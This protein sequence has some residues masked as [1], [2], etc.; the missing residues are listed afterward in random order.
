LLNTYFIVI[1]EMKITIT[2]DDTGVS[3]DTGVLQIYKVRNP[4][5]VFDR[6]KL[7]GIETLKPIQARRMF[8]HGALFCDDKDIQLTHDDTSVTI[9]TCMGNFTRI[10]KSPKFVWTRLMALHIEALPTKKAKK[11]FDRGCSF[12]DTRQKLSLV[13]KDGQQVRHILKFR[14]SSSVREAVYSG[15]VLVYNNK[16][17]P[18]LN[19]FVSGHYKA[20]HPSRTNGNAWL[21]CETMV[22]GEWV[23]IRKA[24]FNA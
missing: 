22:D 13:L 21:Q 10:V 11:L 9:D 23:N 3:L 8:E 2:F 24:Y 12:Y 5:L 4:R 14:K 7:M 15:G 18:S 1:H 17:Y 6:L 20:A 16:P 19:S